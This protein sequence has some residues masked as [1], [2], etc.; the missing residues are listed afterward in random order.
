M[1]SLIVFF[2]PNPSGCTIVNL[3]DMKFCIGQLMIY[4][5][6]V[7]CYKVSLILRH[8]GIR[9]SLS[10]SLSYTDTWRLCP[11]RHLHLKKKLFCQKTHDYDSFLL[12]IIQKDIRLVF[13]RYNRQCLIA[14]TSSRTPL[15][16]AQCLNTRW[17]IVKILNLIHIQSKNSE[18]SIY[19]QIKL[20]YS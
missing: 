9:D 3:L 12:K 16:D 14:L 7:Y 5:F 15:L 6:F 20:N 11:I 18:D 13:L 8:Y 4:I 10:L 2:P 19:I 1:Y 17:K